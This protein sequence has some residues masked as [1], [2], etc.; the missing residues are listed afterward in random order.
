MGQEVEGFSYAPKPEYAVDVVIYNEANEHD[1][2]KRFFAIL[3]EYKPLVISSFNGDHF[4]W[5]FIEDRCIFLGLSLEDEI[6]MRKQEES[7]EYYGRFLI[8]MDCYCWVDRDAFLP[9]GSHGLKAVTR[10]K[11]GYEPVEVDPE[12]MVPMA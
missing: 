8:H 1:L 9:Q 5:P 2:L 11:L 4:D 7:G 3:H 12:D 6:G 10:A